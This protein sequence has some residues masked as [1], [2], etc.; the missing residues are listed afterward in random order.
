MEPE[1]G[2]RFLFRRAGRSDETGVRV[3]AQRSAGGRTRVSIKLDGLPLALD[4]A[5]A[6]I[7]ETPSSPIEYLQ[8]S[9]RQAPNCEESASRNTSQSTPRSRSHLKKSEA[10]AE[11]RPICCGSAPFSR[12]TKSLK[13]SSSKACRSSVRISGP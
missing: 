9:P 13:K 1:E 4:Q 5:G 6:F 2:A 3:S 7:E 10:P 11:L 8:L 12:P